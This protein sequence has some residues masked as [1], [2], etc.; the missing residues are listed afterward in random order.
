[1]MQADSLERQEGRLQEAVEI[2]KQL[3]DAHVRHQSACRQL[4]GAP[5]AATAA[6]S[7]EMCSG[8]RS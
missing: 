7:T 4:R 2:D 8:Y 6:A 3:E 5:K 1:M